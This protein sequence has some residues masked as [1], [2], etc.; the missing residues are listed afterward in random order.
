MLPAP[1][2]RWTTVASLLLLAA[3]VAFGL[4]R[5]NTPGI[6]QDEA[7]FTYASYPEWGA[8]VYRSAPGFNGQPVMMM[9]Y[10]GALK[11]WLWRPLLAVVE[12]SAFWLR[13]PALLLGALSLGLAFL[14]ARQT[15]GATAALAGLALAVTDPTIFWTT[16][17]DWGP[18][19]F[20][21]LGVAGGVWLLLTAHRCKNRLYALAAGL[22]FG[23]AIWDK[24]SFLWLLLS[25]GVAATVAI[26]WK[27]LWP[28]ALRNAAP[29]AL[30]LLIGAAPY[31]SYR[32]STDD[33]STPV[34]FEIHA[35]HYQLKGEVASTTYDGTVI[36]GWA[37][38]IADS[39]KVA[40][41][42]NVF[43]YLLSLAALPLLRGRSTSRSAA[44]PAIFWLLSWTITFSLEGAEKV[45]H[46]ALS[47]PAPHY[48]AGAV[49]AI[50]WSR[51]KWT[52][53]VLA[54]LLGLACANNLRTTHAPY[55]QWAE[56][57]AKPTFSE[58]I[59]TLHDE[60]KSR[61]IHRTAA[62]HWGIN[63]PLGYLAAGQLETHDVYSAGNTAAARIYLDW[64]RSLPGK[65]AVI[66]YSPSQAL[67]TP[68]PPLLSE[69]AE[70]PTFTVEDKFG[71]E[72][73]RVRL[74]DNPA[75]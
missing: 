30:G 27:T 7:I 53:Y 21:R 24:L 3:F 59:Y 26:P 1:T 40:A 11:G 51:A 72:V 68:I 58:A 33:P 12:P 29:V 52:P 23:L 18:V 37:T 6:Y 70:P 10:S 36:Q 2:Q 49:F 75:P 38:D 20:Q 13:F 41:G 55:A 5:V 14:S 4:Y 32:L 56:N 57:G 31:L 8:P 50:L 65:T 22:L 64:V 74:I 73:Y 46:T 69:S 54:A 62:T 67:Y 63:V 39:A 9:T 17:I 44:F 28:W 15:L 35:E 25:L 48:L 19:V 66:A 60:L 43:L 42:H 47:Y 71:R 16:R 34:S 45:H 61:G